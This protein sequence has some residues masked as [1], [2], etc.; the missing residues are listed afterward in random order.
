MPLIQY[1]MRY[2]KDA[3]ETETNLMKYIYA[4]L[5]MRTSENMRILIPLSIG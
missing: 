2:G 5:R 3:P 1:A 4:G